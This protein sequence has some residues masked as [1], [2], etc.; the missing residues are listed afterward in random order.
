MRHGTTALLIVVIL[1]LVSCDSEPTA[2]LDHDFSTWA[3]LNTDPIT[4]TIPG[5]GS[6][7]RNIFINAIGTGVTTS[8]SGARTVWDYPDGTVIIKTVTMP[9]SA[10]GE[11]SPT[12][13]TMILGMLK[14]PDHANS[15]GGWVWLTRDP[16]TSEERVFDT[17]YCITCHID[18]NERRTVSDRIPTGIPNPDREFRDFVFFPYYESE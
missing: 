2:L 7:A 17:T 12:Q 14:T 13:A 15:Q 16:M 3:R 5:H 11:E 4:T 10:D 9:Q 8:T 18:A 1:M 6:G